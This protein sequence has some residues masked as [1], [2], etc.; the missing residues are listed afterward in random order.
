M[1][2]LTAICT[3]WLLGASA[4][5]KAHELLCLRQVEPLNGGGVANFGSGAANLFP[6]SPQNL[7]APPFCRF[8][9]GFLFTKFGGSA[10]VARISGSACA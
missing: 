10:L 3:I 6:G 2:D 8:S 7:V 4:H 5:P 1:F 9:S